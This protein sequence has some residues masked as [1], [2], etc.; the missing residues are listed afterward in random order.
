MPKHPPRVQLSVVIN[1]WYGTKSHEGVY[2]NI[3]VIAYELSG[4]SAMKF[5]DIIAE[6]KHCL[7][8]I[9]LCIESGC[10]SSFQI[11]P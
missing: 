1:F 3:N 2:H 11:V 10:C 5:Y 8:V 9:E 4:L 6:L 7:I